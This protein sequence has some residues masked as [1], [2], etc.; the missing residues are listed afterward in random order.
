MSTASFVPETHASD[1]GSDARDTLRRVGW[2][3]LIKDVA[4]RFRAADGTTHARALAFTSVMGLFPGTIAV[5]GF[6]TAFHFTRFR[7][8]VEQ[9]AA[10]LA[11]GRSSQVVTE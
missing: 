3:R 11:P 7:Q 9:T 2:W 10:G 5:I 6:A 8:V 1:D 4:V